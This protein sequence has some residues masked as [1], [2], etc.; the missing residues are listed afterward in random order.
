MTHRSNPDNRSDN[1]GKL[2][3]KVTNTIE[4]IEA[5]HDSLKFATEEEK[6][7]IEDKNKRRNQSINAMREEIK[8]EARNQNY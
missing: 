3:E 8:D 2:Q 7:N 6:R 5:S 4:N 1:V